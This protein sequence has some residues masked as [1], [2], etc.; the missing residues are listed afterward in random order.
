MFLQQPLHRLLNTQFSD[1]QEFCFLSAC[2]VFLGQLAEKQVFSNHLHSHSHSKTQQLSG[3]RNKMRR[4]TLV[5]LRINVL[6]YSEF[7]FP[8]ITPASACVAL[9]SHLCSC[10]LGS[11]HTETWRTSNLSTQKCPDGK[12]TQNLLPNR[13]NIVSFLWPTSNSTCLI[14]YAQFPFQP[15]NITFSRV[16]GLISLVTNLF[17]FSSSAEINFPRWQKR[18]YLC[19]LFCCLMIIE[20]RSW[21]FYYLHAEFERFCRL[22]GA[23]T[24]GQNKTNS[25]WNHTQ[26]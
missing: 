17:L 3:L 26:K 25:P 22:L 8:H 4:L 10:F 19:C 7:S 20:K 6:L 16:A 12:R 1:F 9:I 11:N 5:A 13:C 14:K 18:P 15:Q 24:E 23:W 2:T 21:C